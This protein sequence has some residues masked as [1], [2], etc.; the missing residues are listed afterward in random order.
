MSKSIMQAE[1]ECY[2]CRKLVRAGMPLPGTGLEEHHV[3]G[4]ANRKL[5][6][7][8][9]LK[10]WLCHAHHNEPPAGVHHNKM[11]MQ[12]L[13]EEGQKAFEREYTN[14][15]FRAIFGRNYRR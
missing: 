9:G 7:H 12:A 5:S 8:Y 6:E 14:E 2:I 1:K 13:H 10:V 11:V 4:A 15:D 3:F